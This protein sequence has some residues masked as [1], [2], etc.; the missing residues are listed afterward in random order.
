MVNKIHLGIDYGSKL[1]GTT[2]ICF[3][4][5]KQLHFLQSEK[6]K[7]ADAKGCRSSDEHE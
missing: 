3:E 2:V 1:A 6:K 4:K 7:D 5:N